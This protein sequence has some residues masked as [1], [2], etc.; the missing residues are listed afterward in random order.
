MKKTT[1]GNRSNF[2]PSKICDVP[3]GAS[4]VMLWSKLIDFLV[5]RQLSGNA[6]QA[7][8]RLMQ[9]HCL[10][11]GKENGWLI[12]TH[13]QLRNCGI[14]NSAIKPA[15]DELVAAGLLRIERQ[16][17]AR[18]GDGMPSLYR[19]TF[20][21]SKF[22]PIAG[23]PYYIEPSSDWQ[24]V[25][26]PSPQPKVTGSRK[27]DPEKTAFSVSKTRP[28]RSRKRDPETP[29]STESLGLEN[30]TPIYTAVY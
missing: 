13:K 10:H 20:L 1:L 23:S 9:E 5:E 21:K 17:H 8:L 30:E 25:P 27:R 16:G 11:A 14:R 18:R 19:L 3:H 29:F 2:K 12:V 24:R 4:F 15:L 28:S 26:K 22:V 6:L 7:L